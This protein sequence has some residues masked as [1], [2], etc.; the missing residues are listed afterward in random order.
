MGFYPFRSRRLT[1]PD[2]ALATLP[3][4]HDYRLQGVHRF[5]TSGAWSKV[6]LFLYDPFPVRNIRGKYPAFSRCCVEQ[7]NGYAI[8]VYDFT[9][10]RCDRAQDLAPVEAGRDSGRQIQEQLQSIS[11]SGYFLERQSVFDCNGDLS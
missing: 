11:Q 8:S 4:V 9:D 6:Q 5:S 2:R 7:G 3:R 1:Y 10:I